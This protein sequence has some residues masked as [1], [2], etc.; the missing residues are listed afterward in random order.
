MTPTGSVFTSSAVGAGAEVGAGGLETPAI[1]F[2]GRLPEEEALRRDWF[3]WE[4][5]EEALEA[6]KLANALEVFSKAIEAKDRRL[7]LETETVADPERG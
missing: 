1:E 5:D 7:F 3:D 2:R 4:V 6:V